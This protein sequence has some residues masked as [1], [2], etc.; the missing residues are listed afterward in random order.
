MPCI[1]GYREFS[2]KTKKRGTTATIG[3]VQVRITSTV[4]VYLTFITIIPS[5][6]YKMMIVYL[7]RN[8]LVPFDQTTR[9]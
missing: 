7:F 8:L 4:K 3:M 6:K 1:G 5:R 9:A 2:P